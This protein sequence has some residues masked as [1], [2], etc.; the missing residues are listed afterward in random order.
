[1]AHEGG[2]IRGHEVLALADA[3]EDGAAVAGHDDA[4][5]LARVDDGDPVGAFDEEEG[6]TH[7]ILELVLRLGGD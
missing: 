1:M 4:V 2:C 3:E 6:P 5:R 7:G